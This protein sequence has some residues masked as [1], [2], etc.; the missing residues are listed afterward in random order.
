MNDIPP[1]KDRL[2]MYKIYKEKYKGNDHIQTYF[3]NIIL[4]K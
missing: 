3:N 2:S 1:V 4:Y